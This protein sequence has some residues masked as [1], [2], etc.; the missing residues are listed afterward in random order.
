MVG[1]NRATK[2]IFYVALQ[3]L[4]KSCKK[5]YT[6]A[7]IK[8]VMDF[9]LRGDKR[10]GED[11]PSPFRSLYMLSALLSSAVR[12]LLIGLFGVIVGSFS[13]YAAYVTPSSMAEVVYA[14][15][16]SGGQ[17]FSPMSAPM[18]SVEPMQKSERSG[19]ME[20]QQKQEMKSFEAQPLPSTQPMMKQMPDQMNEDRQNEDM[21]RQQKM[22]D[23]Q[24]KRQDEQRLKQMKQNVKQISRMIT[25]FDKQLTRFRKKVSIEPPAEILETLGKLKSIVASV[26]NA[27]LMD[28][29]ED[30]DMGDIG[31]LMQDLNEKMRD[32]EQLSRVPEMFKKVDRE[33][34]KLDK[35]FIQD[36]ARLKRT[37]VEA[38]ELLSNMSAAITAIKDGR[39]H[40]GEAFK[41]GDAQEVMDT[42]Q[43]NVFEKMDELR[44]LRGVV[45]AVTGFTRYAKQ[46]AAEIKKN[47]AMIRQ[48]KA[49]KLDVEELQTLQNEIKS[50]FEEVKAAIKNVTDPDSMIASFEE[51]GQKMSEFRDGVDELT[52]QQHEQEGFMPGNAPQQFSQMQIPKG[53]SGGPSDNGGPSNTGGMF[54]GMGNQPF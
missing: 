3:K 12:P 25:Q 28:E 16:N 51:F 46:I 1:V 49:K 2:N 26:T 8:W 21:E 53:F 32:L 17:S 35:T 33:I 39:N 34:A 19:Q 18:P 15:E 23:E 40:A 14:E 31:D 43:T 48:L 50:N 38:G 44:Q 7:V 6:D 20:P 4:A 52:G 9:V 22:Q 41:G 54:G 30:V 37:G 45:D 29:I 42:L 27:Q 10:L 47:D 5:W 11:N 36:V 13:T 24:Q